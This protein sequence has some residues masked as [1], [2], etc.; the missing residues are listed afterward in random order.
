MSSTVIKR[1]PHC[2]YVYQKGGSKR[3]YGSPLRKCTKCGKEFIDKGGIEIAIYGIRDS[4]KSI[5][6]SGIILAAMIGIGS[7]GFG[8]YLQS[9]VIFIVGAFFVWSAIYGIRD[10]INNYAERMEE[11]ETEE[12][13]S[14]RR[15][16][17]YTYAMKLKEG[18]YHVLGKF[19]MSSSEAA[20]AELSDDYYY[21]PKND[22]SKQSSTISNRQ[23]NMDAATKKHLKIHKAVFG[24]TSAVSTIL[25]LKTFSGHSD[26]EMIIEIVIGVI[27]AVVLY[28]LYKKSC[29]KPGRLSYI[30]KSASIS[31]MVILLMYNILYYTKVESVIS[32]IPDD[33]IVK[34]RVELDGVYYSESVWDTKIADYGCNCGMIIDGSLLDGTSVVEITLDQSKIERISCRNHG[35]GGYNETSIVIS[36]SMLAGDTMVEELEFESGDSATVR[37]SFERKVSF[38]EVIFH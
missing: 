38:W 12:R 21:Q 28:K 19:L 14:F 15:L 27:I 37:Y 5:I 24:V 8:I 25:Y 17:N 7:F 13:E 22:G 2:G 35:K 9:L 10:N 20:E 36:T 4:D 16:S 26:A 18:G 3:Y 32:Q 11:L 6:D 29:N 34:V 1:C 30:S 33:K 31:V 23:N